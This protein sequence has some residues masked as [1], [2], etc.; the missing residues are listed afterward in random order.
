MC[1][2]LEVVTYVPDWEPLANALRRVLATSSS[3]PDAKADLCNAVAD[4]K[5][6]IR[7]LVADSDPDVGSKTLAGAQVEIPPRLGLEISFW[8]GSIRIG[9]SQPAS[10]DCDSSL[11]GGTDENAPPAE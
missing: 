7:I 4:K 9:G 8:E 5:I 2:F 1:A 3:E 11:D 10:L 6:A